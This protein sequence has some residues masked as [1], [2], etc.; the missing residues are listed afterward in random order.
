MPSDHLVDPEILPLLDMMPPLLPT[1]ETLAQ[2]RATL[3]APRADQP[4][5]AFAPVAASAPGIDGAPDVPLLIFDPPGRTAR[6]AILQI[7]GGGMVLGSAAASSIPNAYMAAHLGVPVIAVD[8]RLAPEHPFPA[9]QMD[10]LA[11]YDWLVEHADALNIDAARIVIFGESAG[12][13]LA[14]ALALMLRDLGQRSPAGQVL[15]FP[16]INHRTGTQKPGLPHTGDYIWTR[17]ANAYGWRALRGDYDPVDARAG[18]FSPALAQE[19]AGLPPTYIAVGALDLFLEENLDYA[20]ALAGAGVP[21]ELHVYSGA[22]HAF[23]MVPSAAVSRTYHRD[24]YAGLG[25]LLG[26]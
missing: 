6:A 16:M 26:I 20:K 15:I 9:P 18:W 2:L 24:L 1:D 12:G 10:C 23:H 25:R 7:H 4:A 19:L 8:Y 13:G 14:A 17:E 11:A 3:T 22:F 21:I 5:P